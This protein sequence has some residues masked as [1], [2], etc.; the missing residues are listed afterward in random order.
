[1][2]IRDSQHTIRP[3]PIS[4]LDELAP[5]WRALQDHYAAIT[6]LLGNALARD[7]EASWRNRRGKYERWL[8]DPNAFVLI[9]EDAGGPI[10]YAFVT[11]GPGYASWCTGDEMATLQSLSVLPDLRGSGIGSELLD[12]VEAELRR[13]DVGDIEVTTATTNVDA[14]RLYERRGYTRGFVVYVGSLDEQV[15]GD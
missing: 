6:P 7:P 2:S 3:L 1:M 11:I 4:E 5:L 14:Q 10:G 9:A 13:R 8:T 12:A 15:V